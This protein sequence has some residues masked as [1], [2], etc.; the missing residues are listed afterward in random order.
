MG[1]NVNTLSVSQARQYYLDYNNGNECGLTDIQ[2]RN[3]CTRFKDYIDLWDQDET[4]YNQSPQDRLDFDA[5][6]AGVKA[7][8][9][10]R[11]GIAAGAGI[12]VGFNK[13]SDS[14]LN[15][16][17][18]GATGLDSTKVGGKLVGK[19]DVA[20]TKSTTAENS[21][22]GLLLVA[23]AL[24]LAN[25]LIAKSQNANADA[26]EACLEAQELLDE[27]Q[28]KLA[29]QALEM[30]KKQKDMES[31]QE[32]AIAINEEGQSTI[33]DMEGAYNYYYSKIKD[34]TATQNDIMIM[35]GLQ[36]A[37][38][39]KQIETNKATEG[40]NA[41]IVT[42][43]EE[44]YKGV[45]E[46]IEVSDELVDYVASFDKA[47]RNAAIAQGAMMALA[48]AGGLITATKCFVRAS[49]LA[50]SL[51]GSW[52]AVLYVAA[53]AAAGVGAYIYGD[54]AK[55]NLVDYRGI[56]VDT[57]KMRED[58]SYVSEDTKAFQETSMEFWDGVVS[59]TNTDNLFTLT[60]TYANAS[61]TTSTQTADAG[62]TGAGGVS[63][64]GEQAEED[65][66]NKK[67]EK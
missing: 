3:L 22:S 2:Y 27:E 64:G 10:V 16:E 6:D 46:N 60:P 52:A 66:P 38:G 40:V 1:I 51:F 5:D 34:G 13:V 17:L 30:E 45:S 32:N 11:D 54:L 44:L 20:A 59:A 36:L 56:A 53:G 62:T 29:K 58:T 15:F 33:G 67:E 24:V 41:E 50:G 42:L 57:M 39:N 61:T 35:R 8:P 26:A 37:M 9:M 47:T 14:A 25:A 49:A 55:K 7:G 18:K 28:I 65:D 31:M 43:G 23:A 48:S 4:S 12:A 63:T 19:N 21:V